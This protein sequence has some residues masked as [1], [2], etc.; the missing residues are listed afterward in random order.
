MLTALVAIRR[1]QWTATSLWAMLLCMVI[2]TLGTLM[3]IQPLSLRLH[4]WMPLATIAMGSLVR[5]P[6][7]VPSSMPALVYGSNWWLIANDFVMII[8]ILAVL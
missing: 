6:L 3:L 1:L 7:S 8:T 2:A 5:L 4:G